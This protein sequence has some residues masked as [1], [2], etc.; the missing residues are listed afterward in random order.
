MAQSWW[1]KTSNMMDKQWKKNYRHATTGENENSKTATCAGPGVTRARPGAPKIGRLSADFC[2][3]LCRFLVCLPLSHLM[4]SFVAPSQ[5]KAEML[6]SS[7]QSKTSKQKGVV[8]MMTI[9]QHKPWPKKN[10]I[11]VNTLE[12]SWQNKARITES[13][14]TKQIRH[15]SNITNLTQNE[16]NLENKMPTSW[17]EKCNWWRELRDGWKWRCP[18]L[19][20]LGGFGQIGLT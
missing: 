4:L 15:S 18:Q 20:A 1:H 8:P 9:N 19:A 12:P 10:W 5:A 11:K 17:G 16:I 2:R 14:A 3:R 6:G 13:N 7:N